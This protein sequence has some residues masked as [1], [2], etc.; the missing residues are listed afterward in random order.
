MQTMSQL[1]PPS[2]SLEESLRAK[3]AFLQEENAAQ[4]R[5]IAALE[6]KNAALGTLRDRAGQEVLAGSAA[7]GD[8]FEED[9]DDFEELEGVLET[10][11]TAARRPG[12]SR[13][14]ARRGADVA[15][16]ERRIFRNR[17]A[18]GAGGG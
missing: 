4:S 9:D 11:G 15:A 14:F 7:A 12:P 5:H 13:A 8:D 2:S 18:G 17:A 6:A 1:D 3:I 10:G 16:C